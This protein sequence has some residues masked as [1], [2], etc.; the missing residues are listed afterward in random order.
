MMQSFNLEAYHDEINNL[1][2]CEIRIKGHLGVQ[3]T[4]WFWSLTITMEEN[5]YTLLNGPV[6]DKAALHGLLKK[7]VT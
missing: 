6:V 2:V 3:W 7:C 1:M 5:G 4:D